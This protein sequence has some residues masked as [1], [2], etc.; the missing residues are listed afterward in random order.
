MLRDASQRKAYDST[1]GAHIVIFG[2]SRSAK[3]SVDAVFAAA[4][5]AIATKEI[6]LG[7]LFRAAT[8]RL[9]PDSYCVCMIHAAHTEASV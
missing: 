6:D 3:S 1:E 7:P 9:A 8:F 5:S 2:L 4:A